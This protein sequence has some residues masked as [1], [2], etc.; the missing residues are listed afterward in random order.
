M[1]T[2]RVQGFI[3]ICNQKDSCLTY[4]VGL[5]GQLDA[6]MLQFLHSL[7]QVSLL[8][9]ERSETVLEL[10]HGNLQSLMNLHWHSC[11]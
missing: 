5:S 2:N 8:L 3:L 10:L 9:H 1:I 7:L 11:F 6:A 4:G